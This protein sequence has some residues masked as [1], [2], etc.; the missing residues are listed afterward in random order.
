M[1]SGLAFFSWDTLEWAANLF[2]DPP[3]FWGVPLVIAA[4]YAIYGA[5]TRR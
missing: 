5:A 4:L 2:Y 1:D 3:F